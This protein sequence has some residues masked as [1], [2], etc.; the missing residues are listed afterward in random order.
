MAAARRDIPALLR[1]AE[2]KIASSAVENAVAF[3]AKGHEVLD[4]VGDADEIAFTQEEQA[5]LAGASLIH[6][7]PD[8][9]LANG[10]VIR[11]IPPSVDH[12]LDLLLN[13]RLAE[14]RV[15]TEDFRYSLKAEPDPRYST[16]DQ[17]TEAVRE[18]W[19]QEYD[20]L[21]ENRYNGLLRQFAEP[22]P[23]S[24]DVDFREKIPEDAHRTWLKVARSCRL[25]YRRET[26]E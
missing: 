23:L 12:D 2:E 16:P 25:K 8:E 3:D 1:Q 26:R 18:R 15:V 24:A 5:K 14:I 4:K 20:Q 22:L 13:C 10:A 9:T 11:N 17:R 21:R 19:Y 7:H 6:N